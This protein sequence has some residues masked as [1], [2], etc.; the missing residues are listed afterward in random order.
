MMKIQFKRLKLNQHFNF[1]GETFIRV[2][3]VYKRGCCVPEYNAINI[4][5]DADKRC[6]PHETEIDVEIQEDNEH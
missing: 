6:F 3:T 5:N 2:E 4:N 1:G